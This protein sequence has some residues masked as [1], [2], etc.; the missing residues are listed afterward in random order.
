MDSIVRKVNAIKEIDIKKL[1]EF[2]KENKK[3]LENISS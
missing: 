1:Q 2:V 3:E